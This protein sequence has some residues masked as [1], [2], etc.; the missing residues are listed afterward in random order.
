MVVII[1]SLSQYACFVDFGKAIKFGGGCT[2]GVK[3]FVIV[4][5]GF[6]LAFAAFE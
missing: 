4:L 5:G 3:F 6:S 2:S 1:K